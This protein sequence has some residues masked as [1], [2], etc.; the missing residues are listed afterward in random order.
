MELIEYERDPMSGL[1]TFT[2]LDGDGEKT[3]ITYRQ[4]I[5][6]N[7]DMTRAMRND[8]SYW[9]QGVKNGWA[10]V[11]H[12]PNV[13]VSE[14]LAIGVNVYRAPLKDVIAGLHKLHKEHLITTRKNVC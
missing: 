7:I 10:H 14:L 2:H 4:D 13:V 5:Q 9:R 12:I 3:H 11:A 1:E 8:D 6:A